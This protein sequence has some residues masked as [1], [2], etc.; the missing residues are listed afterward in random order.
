MIA[1]YGSNKEK[2]RLKKFFEKEINEIDNKDTV[3]IDKELFGVI[4]KLLKLHG[5]EIKVNSKD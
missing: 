1:E 3:T 4:E 5:Y 2:K